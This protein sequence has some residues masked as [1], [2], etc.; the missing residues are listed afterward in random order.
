ME[1]SREHYYRHWRQRLAWL[2]HYLKVRFKHKER[3]TVLR[4]SKFIPAGG[5]VVD[6]GAHFG[7][8]SKEFCRIHNGSCKVYCFEPVEYTY[9]ILSRIMAAYP[10][11]VIENIALSDK[12]GT[13]RISI[14]VKESG[15]L[16][17]GLSHFGAETLRDYIIEP[18]N[19]VPLDDYV[20]R[21]NIE[22]L[23]FIK[24]DVEG[25]EWL[26][27][28]GGSQSLDKFRPVIYTELKDA[29]T[30]R[31]GYRAQEFF[32]FLIDKGYRA[33]TLD[34]QGVAH[35]VESYTDEVEDYLFL[36]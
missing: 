19:T 15:N 18:I 7:Y 34:T 14:P 31:L 2:Q 25:A 3:P 29:A 23:D 12:A 13:E 17:I 35:R 27:F 28:K 9:S 1:L 32:S 10:N 20:K 26:V 21:H 33:H 22:R 5:V 24:C 4:L 6:V 16:G 36:P 8:L 11:A 30:Q